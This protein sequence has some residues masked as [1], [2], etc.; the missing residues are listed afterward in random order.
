M[1]NWFHRKRTPIIRSLLA[2]V[3]S[4]WLVAAAAPCVMAQP[5]QIDHTP[6]HCLMYQGTT[7]TDMND[8]GPAT[9]ASCKLPD[10]NSPIAA[11]LGD[12]AITPALLAMLPVPTVLPNT[13]RYSRHDFLAPDIPA[14]PLHIRHLTL[15]I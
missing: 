3:A 14:P 6:V 11:T 4:L 13:G 8:C 10:V 9:A 2:S 12:H 1:L 5:H 7:H 15:L